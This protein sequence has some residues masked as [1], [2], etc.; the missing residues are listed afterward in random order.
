M[1]HMCCLTWFFLIRR[2]PV[3]TLE[4]YPFPDCVQGILTTLSQSNGKYKYDYATIPF[5]AELFKVQSC[6]SLHSYKLL[7][8]RFL[9]PL[10]LSTING[11]NMYLT[12][13]WNWISVLTLPCPQHSCLY[14]VSSFGRNV[15]LH[16]HQGWQMSGGVSDYILFL[17]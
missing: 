4:H 16:C 1:L 7:Y 9:V 8:L 12:M 17:Q 13:F 6:N 11:V 3:L 5:L 14:Q 15:S 2:S 10:Y